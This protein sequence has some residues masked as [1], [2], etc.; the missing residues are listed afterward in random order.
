[1]TRTDSGEYSSSEAPEIR[2]HAEER[3]GNYSD[4]RLVPGGARGSSLP[5]GIEALYRETVPGEAT[6]PVQSR[7]AEA[8]ETPD[9]ERKGPHS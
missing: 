7:Y 6:V 8:P 4:W 5:Q 1:M 3:E 2:K 9:Q